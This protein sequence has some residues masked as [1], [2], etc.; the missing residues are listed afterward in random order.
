MADSDLGEAALDL[1][2]E[3][4]ALASV[5]PG[6]EKPRPVPNAKSWS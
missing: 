3:M 6:G 2:P 5:F 4:A 1:V